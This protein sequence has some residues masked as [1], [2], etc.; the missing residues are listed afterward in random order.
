M[1]KISKTSFQRSRRAA[2]LELSEIVQISEAARAMKQAGK[3][4]LTFG[5]GEPDFPTPDHVTDAA[6]AAAR[7]GETTY[8]PTQGTLAL[9]KAIAADAGFDIDPNAI[10]VSTGAK[11]VLSNAFQATLDPGDEVIVP[12]PYWTS[13]ADMLQ[14]CEA[15][16]VT[17]ACGPESGFRLTA[18]QLEAAITPKTRW[19]MLNSPG[20]PTGALY[21]C[22]DLVSLAEILRK[23]P[24]VWIISDEIY[25]HISFEPF[26]SFREAAPDLA[27]RTLIVN[28]VSKAYAM[29][30][31]RL[32]WGIGPAPLIK[33]MVA[34]QGQCTSGASSVSQAA[35]LAALS[36]S[37]DLLATRQADF[38]ARRDTVV[39][40][41][42][43]IDGLDCPNP[44]GAFYVFPSC[45]GVFGRKTP[46]GQ[47]IEDDAGFCQYLLQEALVAL[48]PGRAFGLPGHFRM[49]YAYSTSDLSKGLSR[50]FDAVAALTD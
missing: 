27:D 37:Q 2:A 33:A 26:T 49:S 25:R 22:Q 34:V 32:G 36:G 9:R 8:P 39:S 30:G 45:Q 10:I 41:L 17:I 35:A 47:T 6:L 1:T 50:I 21:S 18:Q 43:A 28:G 44:G 16:Q 20:N 48:V 7:A 42:N 11:Q 46:S 40:A 3:D 38:Q 31:W 5:T 4:V 29:T 23:H 13:Y 14:F 12:A 19:L 24:H 15:K